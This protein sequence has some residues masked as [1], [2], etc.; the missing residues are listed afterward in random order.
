MIRLIIERELRDI[1]GSTKFAVSFGVGA[2]LVLLAFFVGARNHQLNVARYEAARVENLRKMEG[3]TD[4]IRVNGHRI[5][6]PP[7]L[8]F[9]SEPPFL[10]FGNQCGGDLRELLFQCRHIR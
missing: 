4:W 1:I 3:L 7:R 6:L 5:F 2:V 8:Q 9:E 10:L